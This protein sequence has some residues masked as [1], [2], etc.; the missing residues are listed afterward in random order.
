MTHVKNSIL[1]LLDY[2]S[3]A[4][5]IE[6]RPSSVRPSVSSII[7]EVIAWISLK[8][9]LWLHLGHMPRNFFMIFLRIFFVF[10]NMGPYGSQN[11][12]TL[13]LPQIAFESFQPFPEFS[14]QLSSQKYSLGFLKF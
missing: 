11:V 3:R 1:A 6:I 8:L 14:S 2:V 7:S 12:Q 4:H 9:R 10:V 5:E 13:L